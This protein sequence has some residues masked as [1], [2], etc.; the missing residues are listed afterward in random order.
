VET[1]KLPKIKDSTYVVDSFISSNFVAQERFKLTLLSN[2]IN[3]NK[4]KGGY[5]F[6]KTPQVRNKNS[7]IEI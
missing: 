5:F 3:S 7:D 4:E 6:I 2:F 1:K